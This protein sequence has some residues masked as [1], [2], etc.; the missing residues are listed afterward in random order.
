[1]A[2]T[3]KVFYPTNLPLMDSPWL[4]SLKVFGRKIFQ[5]PLLKQLKPWIVRTLS[6]TLPPA[7][8]IGQHYPKKGGA[9]QK[10]YL[11]V[12]SANLWHDWPLHRRMLD[13][14]KSFVRMAEEKTADIILLQ[15]VARIPGIR[16]DEWLAHKLGMAYFYIRA[17]GDEEAIDFE[18]GLAILS[19]F[20]LTDPQVKELGKPINRFTH[21][22]ALSV[23]LE[24]PFGELRAFC[25]HLGLGQWQ[26]RK[27]LKHLR[28]WVNTTTQ[29]ETV[30]IGGDFNARETSAQIIETKDS[31]LDTFRCLHPG[32]DGTT[33]E[34]KIPGGRIVR[35]ARLDYIFLRPKGQHWQ[36]LQAAH[37]QPENVPLSDHHVVLARIKPVPCE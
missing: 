15:E 24:T 10:E 11:T 6:L 3:Q 14:L 8:L 18:E 29:K 21:R 34:L 12:L 26:N 16:V 2:F 27:Q 25:T 37:L 1:M 5:F 19:R 33:H 20:P 28:Q 4:S 22:M 17:N 36:V 35:R 31:W 23:H 9:P 32:K 30:L 7:R 13:R